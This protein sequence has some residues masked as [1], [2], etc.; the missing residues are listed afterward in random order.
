MRTLQAAH[1]APDHSYL[2]VRWTVQE[3]VTY[4]RWLTDNE[5]FTDR[6]SQ[7]GAPGVLAEVVRTGSGG[8]SP[9]RTFAGAHGSA[10]LTLGARLV[11]RFRR[12]WAL[13][14]ASYPVRFSPD[15]RPLPQ[16]LDACVS[17]VHLGAREAMATT[18]REAK[19]AEDALRAAGEMMFRSAA[20]GFMCP[21]DCS[22]QEAQSESAE[23]DR[24]EREQRERERAQQ[25][26]RGG[27]GVGKAG[28]SSF[29]RLSGSAPPVAQGGGDAGGGGAGR[30]SGGGPPRAVARQATSDSEVQTE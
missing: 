16:L 3:C 25:R 23:E 19:A 30:A 26:E 11:P 8:A 14:C 29:D 1:G 12:F 28:V 27:S 4:L 17:M 7:L 24:R 21:C 18:V 5:D 22:A 2:G 20:P 6:L 15:T 10:G 13:G 9:V